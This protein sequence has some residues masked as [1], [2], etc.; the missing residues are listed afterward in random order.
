MTANVA[1]GWSGVVQC[2]KNFYLQRNVK[3]REFGF[4]ETSFGDKTPFREPEGSRNFRS[5]DK[6]KKITREHVLENCYRRIVIR[7]STRGIQIMYPPPQHGI[8]IADISVE[9]SSVLFLFFSATFL[10][11][12]IVFVVMS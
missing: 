7:R 12:S 5:V 11:Y 8:C 2:D 1:L 3:T 10:Q 6:L 4:Y 9:T